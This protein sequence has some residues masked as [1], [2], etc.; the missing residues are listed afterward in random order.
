MASATAESK[1]RM[2]PLS[3]DSNLKAERGAPARTVVHDGALSESETGGAHTRSSASTTS[4]ITVAVMCGESRRDTV[5]R[6]DMIDKWRS[7]FVGS[8][9]R[10]AARPFRN[11]GAAA[12]PLAWLRFRAKNGYFQDIFDVSCAQLQNRIK[13]KGQ[14]SSIC[15][16]KSKACNADHQHS[17]RF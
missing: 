7:R 2:E 17:R 3:S 15:A 1:M 8:D 12:P 4:M 6:C 5:P 11:S 13:Q 14:T 10:T 9:A 16:E